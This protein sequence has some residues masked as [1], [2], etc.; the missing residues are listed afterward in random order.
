[1]GG[2][3]GGE[4]AERSRCWARGR[5]WAERCLQEARRRRLVHVLL[6]P[7]PLTPILNPA[8]RLAAHA[9]SGQ[10]DR[11]A[12]VAQAAP[13]E[14]D[15]AHAVVPCRRQR[16]A[17]CLD[18]RG[19]AE[20]RVRR[21]AS[22]QQL[23]RHMCAQHASA[24]ELWPPH[25]V[26]CRDAMSSG[27]FLAVSRQEARESLGANLS[28][29]PSYPVV[30]VVARDGACPHGTHGGRAVAGDTGAPI[31]VIRMCSASPVA[32]FT[33]ILSFE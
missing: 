10:A 11:D 9:R 19:P 7:W 23:L 18:L 16:A 1:M 15:A 33:L 6:A 31:V 2:C 4:G 5:G 25:F 8:Y 32:G 30:R 28:E 26:A 20:H 12:S 14:L 24:E 13:Y 27:S 22:E 21:I 17:C 3:G 29:G